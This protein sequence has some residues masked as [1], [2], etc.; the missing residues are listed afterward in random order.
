MIKCSSINSKATVLGVTCG[1]CSQTKQISAKDPL[2]I[3][4]IPMKCDRGGAPGE[5]CGPN[6][7]E[8]NADLCE[9]IDQQKLKLQESPEVVPTGEMPRNIELVVER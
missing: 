5:D 1:K 7:F 4:Q 8:I 6:S 2:A 9:F 3:I